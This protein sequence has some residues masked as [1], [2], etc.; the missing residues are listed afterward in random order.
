MMRFF[1]IN[2]FLTWKTKIFFILQT[3]I[4]I[5]IS[6]LIID[7][8]I[9]MYND[10][11]YLKKKDWD[12]GYYICGMVDSTSYP[13]IMNAVEQYDS[14]Y[15]YEGVNSVIY[16]L[17]FMGKLSLE[18]G[19][20]FDELNIV[21]CSDGLIESVEYDI[22]DGKWFSVKN[23]NQVVLGKGWE[24]YCNVG[25]IIS[26]TVYDMDKEY[27]EKFEVVGFM[28]YNRYL[29]VGYS[30]DPDW[31]CLANYDE[32]AVLINENTRYYSEWKD[33]RRFF[34]Q[35]NAIIVTDKKNEF[36]EMCAEKEYVCELNTVDENNTEMYKKELLKRCPYLIVYISI[37]IFGMI[38][39]NYTVLPKYLSAM[40]IYYISGMSQKQYRNM[41][42][43]QYAVDSVIIFVI[44]MFAMWKLLEYPN[45]RIFEKIIVCISVIVINTC[46]FL[47]QI[48]NLSKIHPMEVYRRYIS[49]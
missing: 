33:L 19:E 8:L 28:R 41:L 11:Y 2:S 3:L 10:Y 36:I 37:V 21:S 49:T 47:F 6:W 24:E 1:K 15:E 18:N 32:Y 34:N 16:T 17:D 25:D 14:A 44:E 39:T 27:T 35:D 31:H 20:E 23:T 5:F 30:H 4:M 22:C 26:L 9:S 48:G 45:E 29:G 7:E 46:V 40:Y 42:I 43:K 38:G 13:T 12:N